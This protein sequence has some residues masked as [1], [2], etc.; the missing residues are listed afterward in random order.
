LQIIALFQILVEC[1]IGI[2]SKVEQFLANLL[3]PLLFLHHCPVAC[4]R[5][6]K[7]AYGF[8]SPF[9]VC[10]MVGIAFGLRPSVRE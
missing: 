3:A 2:G 1:G 4:S 8:F 6:G 7:S 9:L 5:K 10:R